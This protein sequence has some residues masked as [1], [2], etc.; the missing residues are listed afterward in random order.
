MSE[1][2]LQERES[3]KE[4][5]V[6]NIYSSLETLLSLLEDIKTLIEENNNSVGFL[7]Q[8]LNNYIEEEREIRKRKK[9]PGE[10]T[11]NRFVKPSYDELKEYCEENGLDVDA[12]SFI[13]YYDSR[14]WRFGNG[15]KM[16]DWKATAINWDKRSKEKQASRPE[17]KREDGGIDWSK[18]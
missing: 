18:V 7:F 16:H 8:L 17:W 11:S 14:G 6:M 3:S 13:S 4:K 9:N 1:E 5:E 12:A 15:A 10:K 2:K